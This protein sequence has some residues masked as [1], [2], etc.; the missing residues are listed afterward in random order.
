MSGDTTLLR[1]AD[2]ACGWCGYPVPE[3]VYL[4]LA[5]GNYRHHVRQVTYYSTVHRRIEVDR[6]PVRRAYCC[7]AH[8]LEHAKQVAEYETYHQKQ[9]E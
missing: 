1:V 4:T 5:T 6:S 8:A 3:P 7:E 2:T 9:P